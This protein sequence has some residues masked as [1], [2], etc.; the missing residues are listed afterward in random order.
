LL[1]A[2]DVEAVQ[3]WAHERTEPDLRDR[4]RVEVEVAPR[5][6]T[7]LEC[8]LMAGRR[9]LRVPSARLGWSGRRGLW[10]LYRFRSERPVRYEFCE[11]SANVQDLL[12]EIDADPT[13]IFWG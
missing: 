7:I 10:T 13:F 1:P 2:K 11:P 12:D 6:L 3:R 5:S 8:S 4:M 9:W